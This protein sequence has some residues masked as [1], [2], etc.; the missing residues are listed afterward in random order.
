MRPDRR[1]I[2]RWRELLAADQMAFYQ[3]PITRLLVDFG[4]RWI[5]RQHV[6]KDKAI[7]DIGAGIGHHLRFEPIHKAR[8]YVCMDSN[9]SVLSQIPQPGAAKVC[10]DCE[11]VPFT[12]GTYD[13]IIA[14]HVLEH[15]PDLERTLHDLAGLLVEGGRMVVV[16]PAD[17]GLLWRIASWLSPSR[18]RLARKG[19]SYGAIMGHEHINRVQDVVRLLERTF[20]VTTRWYFPTRISSRHINLFVGVVCVKQ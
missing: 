15:L 11:A 1:E 3:H 4:H 16:L 20:H 19:L 17:P 12:A 10:G 2:S 13:T 8:R 6:P 9:L 18:R 7:L 5:A 14:S